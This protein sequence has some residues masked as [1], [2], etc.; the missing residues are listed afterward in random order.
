[1]ARRDK[2]A[3]AEGVKPAPAREED[4]PWPKV[5]GTFFRD[6]ETGELTPAEEEE[7]ENEE[8]S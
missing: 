1:M 3:G 6:P 4:L 7:K 8:I 5:G 2:R